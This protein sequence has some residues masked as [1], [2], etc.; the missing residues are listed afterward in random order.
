MPV[1][2]EGIKN[3][4]KALSLSKVFKISSKLDVVLKKR[5]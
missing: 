4:H 3:G 5:H 1:Q 2:V